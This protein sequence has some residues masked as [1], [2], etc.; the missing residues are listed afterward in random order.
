MLYDGRCHK[1]RR[2]EHPN[3]PG[4]LLTVVGE[5]TKWGNYY[6]IPWGVVSPVTSPAVLY[7]KR[8]SNAARIFALVASL[9][10]K[11][12][13]AKYDPYPHDYGMVDL[14]GVFRPHFQRP[15]SEEIAVNTHL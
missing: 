1:L 4:C 12:R 3:P 6:F 2:K 13:E 9:R 7:W 15:V 8:N 14:S 10:R 5:I 11:R